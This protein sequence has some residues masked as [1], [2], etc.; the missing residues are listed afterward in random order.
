MFHA[1]ISYSS[2]NRDSAERMVR[3]LTSRGLRI[4]LDDADAERGDAAMGVPAGTKWR[5]SI[6]D[7]IDAS[8]LVVF[9]DS[10]SWR[11]SDVCRWEYMLALEAGKRIAVVTVGDDDGGEGPAATVERTAGE[12]DLDWIV[13][14][15]AEND[16]VARAHTRLLQTGHSEQ[17]GL[18]DRWFGRGRAADDVE[19]VLG[20]PLASIGFRLTDRHQVVIDATLESEST[21]RKRIRAARVSTLS[22]VAVLAVA[23]LVSSVVA[24]QANERSQVERGN[25]VSMASAGEALASRTSRESR[26]A[27]SRGLD[28]A[29][30]VALA[31]AAQVIESRDRDSEVLYAGISAPTG[32]AISDDG[33]T[34]VVAER[35]RLTIVRD[36]GD[37]LHLTTPE[38]ISRGSLSVSGDGRSAV[39]LGGFQQG[40]WARQIGVDVESNEFE[41]ADGQFV[42]AHLESDGSGLAVTSDGVIQDDGVVEVPGTTFDSPPVAATRTPSGLA[43]LLDNGNIALT[44]S[45]EAAGYRVID[46]FVV[47]YP[48]GPTRSPEDVVREMTELAPEAVEDGEPAEPRTAP[49]RLMLCGDQVIAWD[50]GTVRRTGLDGQGATRTR[51][52]GLLGS[53]VS[54]ACFQDRGIFRTGRADHLMSVPAGGGLPESILRGNDYAG[55]VPIATSPDNSWIVS[56]R[57]D[58]TVVRAPTATTARTYQDDQT[59]LLLPTDSG[60]LAIAQDGQLRLD[61][62]DLGGQR[63]PRLLARRLAT[64]E[65]G[66]WVPAGRWIL[67]VSERGVDH[68]VEIAEEIG[69]TS[70]R[71]ASDGSI[72]MTG[73]SAVIRVDQDSGHYHPTVVQLPVN[74]GDIL[75]ADVVDENSVV[76]LTS[77]G[78]MLRV[79]SRSG[80]IL[81]SK[82]VSAGGRVGAV[83]VLK[84]KSVL[85][86]SS[87]GVLRRLREDFSEELALQL[88]GGATQIDLLGDGSRALVAG[89]K[90]GA[91]IVDVELLAVIDILDAT[92][93]S[94]QAVVLA[95]DG[96]RVMTNL[97]YGTNR[98]G[99]EA[100]ITTKS[101]ERFL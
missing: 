86:M 64:V 82:R 76:L 2:A 101:V 40:G 9:L 20:V 93:G 44:D 57:P 16:D 73:K 46:R 65:D 51:V 15:A 75:D 45:T 3:E 81:D 7:G 99:G 27:L 87:D 70:A 63:V 78:H 91:V 23:A 30:T 92:E 69:V 59:F 12:G 1:F 11:S 94:S 84:D 36:D 42:N 98:D 53:D 31:A 72:I 28:A 22:V 79:D 26:A 4:W 37:P 49:A 74:V 43:V 13:R 77:V 89:V 61:G 50:R 33:E 17:P 47:D 55:M 25:Q 66:F 5:D 54:R 18:L 62:E 83:T 39:V 67:K 68:R 96:T 14:L 58:G 24:Y 34:I 85:T 6:R 100:G 32:V 41:V 97:H 90:L 80:E 56:A 35:D 19:L 8:L 60:R 88:R 21:R 71:S 38:R 95:P 10:L 52:A 29:D 48:K